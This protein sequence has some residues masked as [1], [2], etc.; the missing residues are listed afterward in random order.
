MQRRVPCDC[1]AD[2]RPVGASVTTVIAGSCTRQS[3]LCPKIAPS[4]HRIRS[5][6]IGSSGSVRGRRIRSSL[7]MKGIGCGLNEAVTGV[8]WKFT[9]FVVAEAEV[10]LDVVVAC[11]D[12]VAAVVL[13]SVSKASHQ[14][15]H[16]RTRSWRKCLRSWCCEDEKSNW[17]RYG[18]GS[19]VISAS[20]AVRANDLR[21]LY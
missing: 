1:A 5:I 2:D 10:V 14:N 3:T 7:L 4:F 19:V 15:R 8:K 21:A 9:A 6:T 17:S 11:I 16:P 20:E 18:C 13:P 12:V